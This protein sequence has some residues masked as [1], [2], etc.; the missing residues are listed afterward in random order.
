[1]M[2]LRVPLAPLLVTLLALMLAACDQGAVT[3][4]DGHEPP[5]SNSQEPSAPM[6]PEPELAGDDLDLILQAEQALM[7]DQPDRVEAILAPLLARER[8]PA[9]ALFDAGWADYNLQRYGECIERMERALAYDPSLAS[10]ARVLGFSHYKLGDYDAAREVFA[11]IVADRPEDHRA[12]YGLGQVEL[13]VGEHDRARPLLEQALSLEP[14]Y[15]KARHALA[16]LLHE[17]G[18]EAGALEQAQRVV[19]A[20]PSHD[21][22][23]YLLS[24][25]LAALGREQEA[26]EATDRWRGVYAARDRIG[27]LQRK[28]VEGDENPLLFVQMA[29][30][31]FTLRD[32]PEGVRVLKQGLRRH[33][34]NVT[35]RQR[36]MPFLSAGDDAGDQDG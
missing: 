33:P 1:M 25:V 26:A 28:V 36:L 20:Q 8:P 15:L 11:R 6:A 13:T 32:Y 7:A 35:I 34:T 21:E 9:K 19:E 29:E 23:I 12:Q 31:F 4:T 27:V 16:R 14:E 22:A 2:T 5:V 3:P 10:M 18:D 17:V 30:E 24:Q